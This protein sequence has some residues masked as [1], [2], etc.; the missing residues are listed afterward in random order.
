MFV[1]SGWGELAKH[2]PG[3][4]VE[5]NDNTSYDISMQKRVGAPV[6]F[7]KDGLKYNVDEEGIYIDDST[8]LS[9]YPSIFIPWNE[10]KACIAENNWGDHWEISIQ[11][12]KTDVK[13]LIRD[14]DKEVEQYCRENKVKASDKSL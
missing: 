3:R 2:Y 14:R 13:I 1:N 6:S 8:F 12:R 11:T 5:A 9:F 10:I 7:H 4:N